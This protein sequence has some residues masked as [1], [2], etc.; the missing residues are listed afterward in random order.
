[1]VV[2]VNR[3]PLQQ[4]SCDA[5]ARQLQQP[6]CRADAGLQVG[7]EVDQGVGAGEP[8]PQQGLRRERTASSD[9]DNGNA[10]GGRAARDAERGLAAQRLLVEA[11]FARDARRAPGSSSSSPTSSMTA[12]LP[13]WRRAPSTARAAKPTPQAA[14]PDAVLELVAIALAAAAVFLLWPGRR[15]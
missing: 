4:L 6:R 13:G 5:L 15:R 10:V 11:A 1:M 14:G 2:T 3:R 7:L 8:V 12:S 9:R